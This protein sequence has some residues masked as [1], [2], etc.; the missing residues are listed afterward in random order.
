MIWNLFSAAHGRASSARATMLERVAGGVC[1]LTGGV[2]FL[3]RL[4]PPRS[5]DKAW[6]APERETQD[7]P[8][9]AGRGQ[10]H[11][12]H[13]LHLDD[14]GG[15]FDEAQAQRVELSSPQHRTFGH[16]DAQAPRRLI[17]PACKNSRN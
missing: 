12:D 3:G 1:G 6:N 15:D 13:R 2:R 5:R 7:F 10:V 8:G 14:A 11:P 4:A 16:R 17:A 9:G